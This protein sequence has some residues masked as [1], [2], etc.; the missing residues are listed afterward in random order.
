MGEIK[1]TYVLIAIVL[2][3]LVILLFSRC[4]SKSGFRSTRGGVGLSAG[5]P[6]PE[7][8]F[9]PVAM[10]D[11]GASNEQVRAAAIMLG[12]YDKICG[13]VGAANEIQKLLN[14][15]APSGN[16]TGL[17]GQLGQDY[18]SVKQTPGNCPN[19]SCSSVSDCAYS[20]LS[21]LI[22]TDYSV[23]GYDCTGNKC[24]IFINP[25]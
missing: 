16:W 11:M 19:T 15:Y 8:T 10:S 2:A 17:I 23:P 13:K 14:T 5:L 25:S 21:P 24:Q 7:D 20:Q 4:G 6:N 9:L 18:Y 22:H 3:G 12:K 1:L